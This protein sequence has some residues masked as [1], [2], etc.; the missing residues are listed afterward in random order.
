MNGFSK[1]D[2]STVVRLVTIY[3]AG[4]RNKKT[5]ILSLLL[6]IF[7]LFIYLVIPYRPDLLDEVL[8]PPEHYYE[9][10][11]SD[12][13]IT[14]STTQSVSSTTLRSSLVI[15]TT[16][17]SPKFF[18]VSVIKLGATTTPSSNTKSSIDVSIHFEFVIL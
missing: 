11:S 2:P 6:F 16:S 7:L 18:N 17:R 12:N 13:E 3:E 8:L 10:G 1:C 15:V 14:S 5:L 9:L 4:R